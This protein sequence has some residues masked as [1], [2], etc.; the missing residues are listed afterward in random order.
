[1]ISWKMPGATFIPKGNLLNVCRPLTVILVKYFVHSSST[2]IWKY[3]SDKSSFENTLLSLN[4]PNVSRPWQM[5]I[6]C[7]QT[8]VQSYKKSALALI[9]LFFLFHVNGSIVINTLTCSKL[10]NSLL[11]ETSPAK[12]TIHFGQKIS[13]TFTLIWNIALDFVPLPRLS[14]KNFWKFHH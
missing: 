9:L 5:L 13:V 4:L 2:G 11:I 12:S 14:E 10:F 6:V 8:I 3:A 1:M 7:F